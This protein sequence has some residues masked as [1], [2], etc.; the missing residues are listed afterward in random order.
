MGEGAMG[1]S[2]LHVSKIN[3]F[4]HLCANESLN[5]YEQIPEYYLS[6]PLIFHKKILRIQTTGQI[7]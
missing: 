2:S 3:L 5:I 1:D 6:E 7:S 4:K